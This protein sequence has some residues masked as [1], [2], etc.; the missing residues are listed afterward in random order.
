MRNGSSSQNDGAYLYSL[1]PLQRVLPNVI[2]V[3]RFWKLD[4]QDLLSLSLQALLERFVAE[5]G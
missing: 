2:L 3:S 1:N 5:E 4:I